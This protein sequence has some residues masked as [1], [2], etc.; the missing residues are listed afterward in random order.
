MTAKGTAEG[1]ASASTSAA[2]SVLAAGWTVA[3]TLLA[4]VLRLNLRRRAANGREITARLPE[5]RGIDPT[6]RPT[7]PL[8][9]MHAASVGETMSILPVLEALRHRTKVLLTTGTVTSQALLDRRIPE[10]G[11]SGD[12]LHRFAP[13]DVPSWVDRFLSHWRPDAACFVESELWPNQLAACRAMGIPLMLVNARMS[14]RSFA[15]WRSVPGL[16]RRVLGGFAHVQARGDQD[17]DRLKALGATH[18]E[19]PGDLK[20]AAPPLPV[21]ATEHDRLSKMLGDRPVWLAASTHPNEEVLVAAAHRE[22]AARYPNLLTIIAPRH[23]DRGPVLAGEL[24][25]PRRTAGQD[26]PDGEGIWIADT[27]G[28]LGLWYRLAPIALVGRS[29]V[30]PGGGQNP[31]EPARLGCAVAVGPHTGNFS[32]HVALLREAGGLVEVADAAS[33]ARFVSGMLDNPDQRRRLGEHAAASVRRH[34]DL[35]AR[36]AETLLSLLP[37]QP[38]LA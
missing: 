24:N 5:R 33:L 9:W 29:L 31:L 35:P 23:P 4:P 26:P 18:V 16:A 12:V 8:L 6:P 7:G 32:D 20:F 19:S 25:A 28:E 13:L 1:T 3:A 11:L 22:L 36:T 38:D 27:M 15:W 10:Q 37:A 30:A 2:T 21:D 17:A 34:A 14:D